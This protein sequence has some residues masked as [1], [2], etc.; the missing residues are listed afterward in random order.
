MVRPLI[1][2]RMICP[3]NITLPSLVCVLQAF[4]GLLESH[5]RHPPC[6]LFYSQF[7]P[8]NSGPVDV[9]SR[10]KCRGVMESVNGIG[11]E[12]WDDVCPLLS[13]GIGT[14]WNQ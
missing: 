13:L 6:S 12:L 1:F 5:T 2:T 10:G 7:G 11:Y 8:W 4:G 3:N 9:G 14:L